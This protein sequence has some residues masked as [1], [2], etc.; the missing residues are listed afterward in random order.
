M[1]I[2]SLV[3]A[4]LL[5]ST[6]PLMADISA[7]PSVSETND[8]KFSLGSEF[9]DQVRTKY[10]EG[11]YREFLE[12]MDADYKKAQEESE[13][14]GL[15]AIRHEDALILAEHSVDMDRWNSIAH[16]WTLERNN[17]LLNAVKGDNST[18]AKKVQSIAEE[19][20]AAVEKAIAYSVDLRKLSPGEGK[21]ADE[22]RLIEIDLE[23]EYKQIHL[24]S[25]AIGGQSIPDRREKHL[26]LRMEKM[27]QMLD[28]SKHFEDK[29]I[30]Q[31]IEL[32]AQTADSRYAKGFDLSDLMNLAR[33]KTSHATET[34]KKVALI[35]SSYQGKFSDLTREI[36]EQNSEAK[37]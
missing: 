34:E 22:N 26:V 8:S 11:G 30:K 21:N 32:L 28:A 19:N 31:K 14:E 23:S 3:V 35:L 25:Q 20:D 15:I 4:A 5:C 1:K 12:E 24:D 37:N 13:L 17:D 16:T 29:E 9:V 36:F 6:C 33:G 18:L 10:N 7:T 2:L 27:D